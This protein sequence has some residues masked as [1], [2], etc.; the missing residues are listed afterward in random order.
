MAATGR[1]LRET[2][3]PSCKL[4]IFKEFFLLKMSS[5]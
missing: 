5:I 3:H 2:T 1:K 4:L